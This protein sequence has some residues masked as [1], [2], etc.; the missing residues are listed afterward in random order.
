MRKSKAGEAFS[1]LF[2]GVALGYLIGIFIA[3]EAWGW[4]P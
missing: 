2:A 3:A 4:L 1:Y